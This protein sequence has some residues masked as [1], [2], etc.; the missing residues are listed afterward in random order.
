MSEI[1]DFVSL[2]SRIMA[3]IRAIETQRPDRLFEDPLAAQL[4]GDEAIASAAPKVKEYEDRGT[5]YV[6]VRTRFF[7]D[8]L[9]SQAMQSRQVVIL[10]AGMDTRAF[11]LPWFPD[12]HLYELD[13]PE[14]LN[15][16]ESL[17]RNT[18]AKCDRHPISI[19]LRQPWS[20][21]LIAQGYQ[22]NIPSVWLVEGLLYYLSET[23]AHELLKTITNLSATG[24]LLGADLVNVKLLEDPDELAKYWRYGCDDPETLLAN[25]GWKS[26]VLQPGDEGAN[27]G[28]Y[29]FKFPPRDVPD[30]GRCFFVTAKKD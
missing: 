29:T 21:L 26:S 20:N 19:D 30:V 12:T 13:R 25:Y 15:T 10:G 9:L 11:R 1:N 24:S 23:E 18:S 6:I 8:F 22:A 4:A 27:F 5:P 7:D 3:A 28:R 16:K 2:T 14:V 17:L